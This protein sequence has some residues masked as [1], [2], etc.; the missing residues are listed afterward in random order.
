[1]RMTRTDWDATRW[2]SPNKQC[3]GD[4]WNEAK[5]IDAAFKQYPTATTYLGTRSI[6]SG[7]GCDV[8]IQHDTGRIETAHIISV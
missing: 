1:M 5:R 2:G 3:G 8:A 7:L 4:L 6:G